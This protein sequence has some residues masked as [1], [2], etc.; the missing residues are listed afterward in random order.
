ME[1]G[2]PHDA[3]R[4][5]APTDHALLIGLDP[6]IAHRHLL[7][8]DDRHAH[9][10]GHARG[11]LGGQQIHAPTAAL[12]YQFREVLAGRNTRVA[13]LEQPVFAWK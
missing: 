6:V 11:R 10:M 3:P 8:A 7:A 9:V 5:R 13:D 4:H 2:R 1:L 12:I